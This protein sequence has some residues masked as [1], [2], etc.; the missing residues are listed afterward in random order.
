MTEKI[1]STRW[2]V[3]VIDWTKYRLV[4]EAPTAA[5][6]IEQAQQLSTGEI[7]EAEAIGGGQDDWYAVPLNVEVDGGV[8]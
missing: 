3:T 8:P 7:W 6:A 1:P 4:V 2:A 5:H